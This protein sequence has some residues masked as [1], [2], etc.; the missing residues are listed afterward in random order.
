MAETALS[1]RKI[2]SDRL[3]ELIGQAEKREPW[4]TQDEDNLLKEAMKIFGWHSTAHVIQEV[5]AEINANHPMVADIAS[6]PSAHINHL[7]PRT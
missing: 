7:T 5:Y 2:F 3:M 4:T 1:K 6:F